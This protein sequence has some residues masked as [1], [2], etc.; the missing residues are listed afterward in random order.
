MTK[1]ARLYHEHGVR[2]QQIAASLH[3]SQA[4]VSR[5]L[6]RAASEG[7]VRTVVVTP[8]GIHA[9]LEDAL[10]QKYG[11]IDAVV[12]DVE[13]TD[14]DIVGGIAS[15]GAGYLEEAVHDG[16]RI[17]ISSWSDTLLK[18]VSRM[19]SLRNV[20]ADSVVQMVGG[21]GA[22][23]AQARANSL[24]ADMAALLRA[25]PKFVPS[26]GL[27]GSAA[28]RDTLMQDPAVQSVAEQWASLTMAL[29]GVG[30]LPPSQLLLESG[31][32]ATLHDQAQLIAAGAVGDICCRFFN[33]GGTPV[34][35]DLDRRIVGIDPV[36]LRSIP[37]R[38]AIAGGSAKLS[39]IRAALAGKWV[40]VILT[41]LGT[42]RGLVDNE[43]GSK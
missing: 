35:T 2:Q 32:A 10:A 27:V 5:L 1:V 37:R 18:V 30:R 22:A 33:G 4:R 40:N 20:A 21:V 28:T 9:E 8:P 36:T 24:L 11:L 6:K 39:A 43:E 13:G 29:V 15:V 41:D 26:P 23:A 14:E 16:D 3:L 17:G 31:N 12:V 7:I 38:I 42:A 34:A 19:R 25:E